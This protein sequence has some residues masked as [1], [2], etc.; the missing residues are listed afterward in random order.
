MRRLLAIGIVAAVA[1]SALPANAVVPTWTTLIQGADA[2]YP[3]AIVQRGD[4][5][6]VLLH[7][8][9]AAGNEVCRLARLDASGAVTWIRAFASGTNTDCA[10]MSGDGTGLYIAINAIGRV[11]GVP[12]GDGWDT[13]VRKVDFD[14]G[15]LWTRAFSTSNSELSNAIAVA[16]GVVAI[17]GWRFFSSSDRSSLAFVRTYDA[18]GNLGWTHLID[19]DNDDIAQAIAVDASGAYAAI[20]LEDGDTVSIEAFDG[21]GAHRWTTTLPDESFVVAMTAGGGRL[22]A[23]G[24]TSGTF[25]GTTS[26]GGDDTFVATFDPATGATGW[27]RQFGSSGAD[28]GNSVAFGPAGVYVGGY[29]DGSL[30]RFESRGHLDAFVRAYGPNGKRRW[31]RQFGTHA[32]DL[33]NGVVA[34]ATGVTTL[35]ITNGNLGT[36]HVEYSAAFVRRWEPA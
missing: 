32:D 27:V 2:G 1:F 23:A 24:T 13:Y 4:V 25:P 35:G 14:A 15:V 9:D 18:D 29:T 31:T 10:G 30:P 19:S 33:A 36:G 26:A 11:D 8:G 22:F 7:G 12:G 3:V 34:D 21:A 6:F 16:G 28:E 5:S 20:W 17:G